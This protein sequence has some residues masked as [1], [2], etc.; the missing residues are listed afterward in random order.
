MDR[1]DGRPFTRGQAVR[2][3]VTDD[4]LGGPH[5]QRIYQGVYVRADVSIDVAVRAQAAL[6]IAPPGSYASH[7]TAGLLWG[8]WPPKTPDTHISVPHGHRSI[9][10]GVVAHRADPA[11]RT[12]RHRGILTSEPTAVFLQLASSRLPLLDLVALGDGLVRRRR[13][14]PEALIEA[15]AAYQGKGARLARRAARYVRAG[16]DSPTE[17]RLRMLLVL[18]GLPEPEVNH[19]IR[20]ADGAWRQRFDL[21]YPALK[22]IIEYDGVQHLRNKRQWS[23]DLLRREQLER[24][25]WRIIVINSDALYGDPRGTLSRVR[26]AMINRG[27]GRLRARPSAAWTRAFVADPGPA[28]NNSPLVDFSGPD[29]A[30]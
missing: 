11:F 18:A 28:G 5:F 7:H 3:G 15:A 17:S 13:T 12:V 6:L 9:R 2:Q 19:I 1:N 29:Q 26:Q 14:T 16:V 27:A 24:E 22:L 4:E 8:S 23:H 10:N 21:C 30:A 20:H 25:G